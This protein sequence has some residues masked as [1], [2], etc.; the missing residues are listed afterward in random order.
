MAFVRLT[1]GC[2]TDTN[3]T[4]YNMMS[5]N[6]AL[7]TNW[8]CSHAIHLYLI[9][10]EGCKKLKVCVNYALFFVAMCAMLNDAL[11]YNFLFAGTSVF[12]PLLA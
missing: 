5:Y 1:Q 6:T 9:V 10:P 11:H 4:V 2:V 3:L 12:P 8:Y 7:E